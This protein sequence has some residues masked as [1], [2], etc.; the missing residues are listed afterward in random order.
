MLHTVVL[1]AEISPDRPPAAAV[2]LDI[3]GN[4]AVANARLL[5]GPSHGN[6]VGALHGGGVA[7]IAEL[8]SRAALSRPL[9]AAAAAGPAPRALSVHLHIP[10]PIQVDRPGGAEV[11]VRCELLPRA[12]GGPLMSRAVVEHAGVV[13]SVA[14]LVWAA[15]PA[16]T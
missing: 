7:I 12:E 14:D 15:S 6:P 2:S 4:S 8:A 13:C 9:A 1:L 3:E 11:G 10:R 16:G 5:L